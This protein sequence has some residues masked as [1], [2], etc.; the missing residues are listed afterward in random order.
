MC[1]SKRIGLFIGSFDP[2]HIGHREVVLT[3]LNTCLFDKIVIC[4]GTNPSK[5]Y[6]FSEYER[7]NFIKESFSSD[8]YENR[9]DVISRQ[10]MM[11][12]DI[13]REINANALI[14]GIRNQ[15]D[16]ANEIE[17]ANVNTYLGHVPTLLIPTSNLVSHVSSTLV[18]TLIDNRKDGINDYNVRELLGRE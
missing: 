18:R 7:V 10:N 8:D 14:K 17:Q 5:K 13:A 4:V 6:M 11:A 16:A 12:C 15:S 9:I 2:F 1:D 3:A